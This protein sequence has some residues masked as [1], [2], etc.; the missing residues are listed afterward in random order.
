MPSNDRPVIR[1]NKKAKPDRHRNRSNDE[2]MLSSFTD[3]GKV[4][5][6]LQP[7]VYDPETKRYVGMTGEGFVFEVRRP[8]TA[9]DI[10]KGIRS[11]VKE[12]GK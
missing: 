3:S 12:W 2:I 9:K 11:F 8:Q 1:L 4:I 5:C 10:F 6:R 7:W